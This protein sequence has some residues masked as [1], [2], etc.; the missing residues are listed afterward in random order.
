VS[1]VAIVIQLVCEYSGRK[2][3]GCWVGVEDGTARA[4]SGGA[5]VC[6]RHCFDG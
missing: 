1:I 4:G 6:R 2:N 5:V 3:E